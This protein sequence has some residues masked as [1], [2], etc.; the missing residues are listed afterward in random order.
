M[1]PLMHPPERCRKVPRARLDRLNLG[2]AIVGQGR[3]ARACAEAR[4][5]SG[6]RGFPAAVEP[7]NQLNWQR[8]GRSHR[9]LFTVMSSEFFGSSF[10]LK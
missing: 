2:G 8:I 9:D 1:S 6:E 7:V 3:P 4:K 5:E 10:M